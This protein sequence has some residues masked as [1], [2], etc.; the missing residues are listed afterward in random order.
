METNYQHWENEIKEIDDAKCQIGIV[1]DKPVDCMTVSC[2][3]CLRNREG[4]DV[5][6]SEI[7]LIK[8]CNEPY[9][10]KPLLTGDEAEFI[11]RIA[12]LGIMRNVLIKRKGGIDRLVF[13][14][15]FK[16]IATL[17]IDSCAFTAMELD[18][19]YTIEELI[20]K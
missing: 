13:Y 1:D 11:M 8:W 2:T 20:G 6:C 16:E 19:E 5:C 7:P 9:I 3:K 17:Y 18:K 10:Q 12:K 4:Y 15:S 14:E